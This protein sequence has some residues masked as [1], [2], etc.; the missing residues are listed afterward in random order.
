MRESHFFLFPVMSGYV[1]DVDKFKP[2]IFFISREDTMIKK[3]LRKFFQ[4]WTTVCGRIYSVIEKQNYPVL[5]GIPEN[6]TNFEF[7]IDLKNSSIRSISIF[8]M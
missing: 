7:G 8:Y 3:N 5:A 6:D 2:C 4:N 1:N